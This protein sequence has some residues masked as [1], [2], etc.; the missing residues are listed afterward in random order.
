MRDLD[1]TKLFT[2]QKKHML[3]TKT[4]KFDIMTDGISTL[5]HHVV[6][7]T[8]LAAGVKKIV[9]QLDFDSMPLDLDGKT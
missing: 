4:R 9:V 3:D 7:E 1:N 5:H 2:E 8:Q 6:S